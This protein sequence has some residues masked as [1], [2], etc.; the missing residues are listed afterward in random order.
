MLT[1]KYV[2]CDNNNVTTVTSLF[3]S[4]KYN[5]WYK[6]FIFF[7]FSFVDKASKNLKISSNIQ[8]THINRINLKMSIEII[9]NNLKIFVINEEV[10]RLI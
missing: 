3:Q 10:C 2:I 4:L 6:Y 7:G 8:H 5:K 1:I 9:E